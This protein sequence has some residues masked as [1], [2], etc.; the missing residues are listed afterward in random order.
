MTF[1]DGEKS[2]SFLFWG[3][4]MLFSKML[5]LQLKLF[6]LF[7]IGMYNVTVWG[8]VAAILNRKTIILIKQS[9]KELKQNKNRKSI[10]C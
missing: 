3:G 1:T 5:H 8:H 2:P 10:V 6:L 4:N 9:E 7:M